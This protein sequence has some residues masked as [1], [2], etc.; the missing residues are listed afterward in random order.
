MTN[1][2]VLAVPFL[3]SPSSPG[4]DNVEC[5]MHCEHGFQQDQKGCKICKCA[6]K[7]GETPPKK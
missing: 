7:K 1:C 3:A 2:T 6:L 5:S 4:C